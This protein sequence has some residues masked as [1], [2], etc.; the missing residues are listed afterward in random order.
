MMTYPPKKRGLSCRFDVSSPDDPSTS[1]EVAQLHV[2][3]VGETRRNSVHLHCENRPATK[4]STKKSTAVM[5]IN[6]YIFST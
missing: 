1:I 5:R 4:F 3:A 6:R 2:Q